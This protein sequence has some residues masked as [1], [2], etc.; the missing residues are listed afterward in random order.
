MKDLAYLQKVEKCLPRN[1]QGQVVNPIYLDPV[2]HATYL[3]NWGK[4]C[5]NNPRETWPSWLASAVSQLQKRGKRSM[6]RSP[7]SM[8]GSDAHE[9][10]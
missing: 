1:S 2:W 9:L 8:P 6:P 10:G 3:G 7:A 5:R 4:W